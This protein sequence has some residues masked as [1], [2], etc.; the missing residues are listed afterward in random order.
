MSK[1][2]TPWSERGALSPWDV[3]MPR[4]FEG[5]R[6]QMDDLLEDF[7]TAEDGGRARMYAPRTNVAET[8]KDFEITVDLPG[9][10]PE[11]FNVELRE[12]HLW[13]T[14]HRKH[15]EEEKGKTYHRIERSYGE[16]RRAI[17]L[18]TDVD[19]DKVVAE[20]K[21]EVLKITVPKTEAAKPKKIKVKT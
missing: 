7:F 2:L 10:K 11:D 18:G 6:R 17:P 16:F 19:P 21:D 5:L 3:R 9:M 1:G 15:E 20:Y 13:L 8:E 14:G 12:G 4:W